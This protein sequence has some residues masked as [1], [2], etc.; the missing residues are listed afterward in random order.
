MTTLY[1]RGSR[2]GGYHRLGQ[3][4]DLLV[5]VSKGLGKSLPTLKMLCGFEL[6]Q[7]P[8]P[9]ELQSGYFTLSGEV[10]WAKDWARF[11]GS[12]RRFCLLFLYR[13]AFPATCHQA[14]VLQGLR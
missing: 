9:R 5:E 7:D 4:G 8:L 13:F 10:G 2:Y 11:A 12:G 3:F 6:L 1:V 14:I